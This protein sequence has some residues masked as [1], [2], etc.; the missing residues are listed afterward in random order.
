M[1]N[2]MLSLDLKDSEEIRKKF[3]AKLKELKFKKL[4]K[5]DTVWAGSFTDTMTEENYKLAIKE[6]NTR[7]I[8]LADEFNIKE[9]TYVT[10]IGNYAPVGFVIKRVEGAYKA[11]AYDLYEQE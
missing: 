11:V 1:I 7:L 5:V 2:Y 9:T 10:Q 6:I 8:K 3:N 4:A